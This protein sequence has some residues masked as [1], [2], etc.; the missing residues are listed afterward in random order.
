M[1]GIVILFMNTFGGG[2][3]R[4]PTLCSFYIIMSSRKAYYY[5]LCVQAVCHE[6]ITR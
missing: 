1:D 2:T 5:L 6:S 3:I 4:F